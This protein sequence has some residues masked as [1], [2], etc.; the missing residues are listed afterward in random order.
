MG[1]A[2][3]VFPLIPNSS[4]YYFVDLL[5]VSDDGRYA[6]TVYGGNIL[7]WNVAEGNRSVTT[8]ALPVIEATTKEVLPPWIQPG[9]LPP[10][11]LEQQP[12]AEVAETEQVDQE[13][14]EE[15]GDE[16]RR[17]LQL[18]APDIFYP[19][20][21]PV[22]VPTIHSLMTYKDRLV[23]I[24]SGYGPS[25]REKLDY[26]PALYEAYSTKILL[27]DISTLD[28]TGKLTLVK[29]TDVHGRFDSIRALDNRAHLVTFSGV[30]TYTFIDE[31]LNRYSHFSDLN[32]EDYSEAA[33]E[34][35]E[36]KLIPGLVDRLVSDLFAN[37][38]PT[39][40]ARV[41]ML[42]QTASTDGKLEEELFSQGILNHFAQV[43]S[44][45][46]LEPTDESNE[47]TVTKTG[48]FM[49][50][51]WGHTYANEEMLLIATQSWDFIPRVGAGRQTTYFYGF[52]LLGN[53][54]ATPAAVGSLEGTLLNEFSVDIVDGYMR[55]AITIRR[56]MWRRSIEDTEEIDLPP[57]ENFVKVLKIPDLDDTDDLRGPG[58]YLKEVGSTKSLGKE[59]E[60]FFGVR[61]SNKFAYLVTFFQVRPGQFPFTLRFRT[62]L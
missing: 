3:E 27:Y 62:I 18:I 29:D 57:T 11:L 38:V 45:D 41:N 2:I 43:T 52:A 5:K 35:A 59:N 61:F 6:F 30:D 37:G 60:T 26:K 32:D 4:S 55:V 28:T 56:N 24:A 19:C 9:P 7:V 49:S 51:S 44:F 14:Q 13:D 21:D 50:S 22:P 8:E 39:D 20:W 48:A 25:I 33:R 1:L 46:M 36:D 47:L 31:P 58:P 15:D 54:Q 40:I 10:V 16:N 23:V 34:L 12:E 42:Q 17:Y 53:G